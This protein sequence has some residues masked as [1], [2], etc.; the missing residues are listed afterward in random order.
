MSRASGL[1]YNV[2]SYIEVTD[3]QINVV[4]KE[5]PADSDLQRIYEFSHDFRLLR[6]AFGDSYWP[7]HRLLRL[8]G[9]IDHLE[10]DCPERLPV[11]ILSW[12]PETGWSKL[13]VSYPRH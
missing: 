6:V 4:T 1:P 12:T 10:E 5:G 2:T 9:K 11:S 13:G 8:Q 3:S 7:Q